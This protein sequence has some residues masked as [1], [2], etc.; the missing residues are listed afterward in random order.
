METFRSKLKLQ[1]LY[2]AQLLT[3]TECMLTKS[4]RM[5]WLMKILIVWHVETVPISTFKVLCFIL[6][7]KV[8]EESEYITLPFL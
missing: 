4:K 3:Q 6:H 1:I 2:Y 7:Q 5:T 8:K